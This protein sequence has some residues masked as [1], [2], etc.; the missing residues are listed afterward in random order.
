MRRLLIPAALLAVGAIVAPAHAAPFTYTDPADMPANGGLDIVSVTYA[1]AGK[2]KGKA[3]VP[4]TLLASMT[5]TAPP[6]EQAGVG[7]EVAATVDGCGDLVFS[8]T[9]GTVASGILGEALVFV[10]C[11]GTTDPTSDAQI[12]TPK[13]AV[14]GSTLTWSIALKQLPKEVRAGAVLGALTSRVDLVEPA[15]GTR[16][17]GPAP[18]LFDTASSDKTWKIG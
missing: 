10:G 3:Y 5:L 17:V 13:F 1:T 8:Y 14:N 6:L 15:F 2:G 9:P 7:Y 11:G 12:L 4:A 18:G 16:L